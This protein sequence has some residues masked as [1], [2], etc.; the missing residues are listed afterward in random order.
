MAL[1]AGTEGGAAA[2]AHEMSRIQKIRVKTELVVSLS[3]II[4]E[5]L[6]PITFSEMC[7]N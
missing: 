2:G 1:G 4:L 3:L 5:I 7:R 6:A